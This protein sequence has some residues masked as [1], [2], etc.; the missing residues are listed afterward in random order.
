MPYDREKL[1]VRMSR[2]MGWEKQMRG[3]PDVCRRNR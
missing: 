1:V 3:V 2:T